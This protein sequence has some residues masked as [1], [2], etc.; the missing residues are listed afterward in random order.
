MLPPPSPLSFVWFWLICSRK[1]GSTAAVVTLDTAVDESRKKMVD[2]VIRLSA[3]LCSRDRKL[4]YYGHL[5]Y[6]FLAFLPCFLLFLLSPSLS[7][8]VSLLRAPSYVQQSSATPQQVVCILVSLYHASSRNPFCFI[9]FV[10]FAVRI[11]WLACLSCSRT[12]Y[13]ST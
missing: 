9:C 2:S 7:R 3:R 12:P 5:E 10:F 4:C 6:D 11:S 1:G 8:Y 13:V